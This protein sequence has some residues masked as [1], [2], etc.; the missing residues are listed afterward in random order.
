MNKPDYYVISLYWAVQT[1]TTVGYGDVNSINSAE[2]LFCA[3]MMIIGVIAFSFANGA[4]T[5][6]ISNYD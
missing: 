3:V 2:R 4:L 6:I 1:A 5:S